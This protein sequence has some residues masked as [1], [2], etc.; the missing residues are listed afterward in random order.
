MLPGGVFAGV[1]WTLLTWVFS[2]WVS[3]GGYGAYG[4]LAT[5]AVVMLWLYYCQYVLLLGACF[6]RA[7][8]LGLRDVLT[9]DDAE[10]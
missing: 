1:A 4:S 6:N 9:W 8:T 2:A 3:R 5:V 7:L 10:E